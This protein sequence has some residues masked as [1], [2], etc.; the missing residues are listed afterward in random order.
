LAPVKVTQTT[1]LLAGKTVTSI[2]AGSNHTCAV[3]GGEAYCW[4]YNSNGQLGNSTT[5]ASN[6]PVKVTQTTNLLAGK[7]VTSVTASGNHAC[8]IASGEA[9]CWGYNG[10]GQLGNSSL[11]QSAA[12]VKVTQAAGLLAGKTL[13]EITA[14]SSHTCTIASGEAFCWGDNGYGQLGDSTATQRSNPVKVTAETGGLLN[15][16]LNNMVAGYNT[17]CLVADQMLY[18]W[19]L[20]TGYELAIT[21]TA[22]QLKPV[23]SNAGLM[24][25][26]RATVDGT[27]V[28]T[29]TVSANAFSLQTP[30][31]AAGMTTLTAYSK[32]FVSATLVNAFEYK[33]APVVTSISP[34]VGSI[35]GG[36]SIT[37]TGSNFDTDAVLTIG[38]IPANNV[39]VVNSQTITATTP[40]NLAQYADIKVL[41]HEGQSATLGR[42]YLYRV[43]NATISSAAPT[44]GPIAGGAS[45]TFTGSN[46]QTRVSARA[47]TGSTSNKCMLAD[48]EA[49]C[50][51][52]NEA[53][54]KS[55]V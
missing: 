4:G 14:G 16:N 50:W 29:S 33:S 30:A 7:T 23:L 18:C 12:P 41:N 20:N 34:G 46:V 11:T 25:I 26:E 15:R 3:A 1:N 39:V 28:S 45:V 22:H 54:R 8:V 5:T 2:T 31:H 55:V 21:S 9:Y 27:E 6:A 32:Y 48:G 52:R 37:I 47:L 35:T 38:G 40:V 24:G 51:G 53:D 42:S 17:T 44:Q 10:Y 43:T 19:G 36:D 13:T 49:Y